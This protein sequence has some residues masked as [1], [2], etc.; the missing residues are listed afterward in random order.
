MRGIKREA[1]FCGGTG[2]L[3]LV[4]DQRKRSRGLERDGL[5][6]GFGLKCSK[7][8]RF[9][10]GGREIKGGGSSGHGGLAASAQMKGKI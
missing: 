10:L 1:E 3:C 8:V 2:R 4:L 7:C 5:I 6:L 9:S